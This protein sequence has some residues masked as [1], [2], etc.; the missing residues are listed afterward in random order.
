MFPPASTAFNP[1]TIA[2]L[3]TAYERA[4]DGQPPSAHE[5]I[6]KRIIELAS[7]GERDP[8]TLCHGALALLKRAQR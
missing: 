1:E 5:L 2:L 8:D 4:I 7:Q 3:S 6:A